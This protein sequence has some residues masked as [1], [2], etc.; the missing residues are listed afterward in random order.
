VIFVLPPLML[1]TGLTLQPGVDAGFHGLPDLFGGRQSARTLHL[2]TANLLVLFVIVHLLTTAWRAGAPSARWP[3]AARYIVF[4]CADDMDGAADGTN[5]HYESID[6]VDAFHPQTMLGYA[7]NDRPLEVGHGA[8]VRLRVERQLGYK[9]AKY[10]MR[11]EAVVSLPRIGKGKGGY[12]E[13]QGYE[14]YAGA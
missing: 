3:A 8:P 7:L 12:W 4:H 5:L 13:D 14:W 6:L 1:L 9:H 2:V 10:V 11:L